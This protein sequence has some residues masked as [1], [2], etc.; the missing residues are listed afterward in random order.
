MGRGGMGIVYKARQ[1]SLNRPVAL[2]MIRSAALASD[3]ELRRFQNEAEAVAAARP[4]AHR[5]DPGSGRPRRPALFQHEADRRFQP[6][7]EARRLHRRP[8]CRRDGC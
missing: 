8:E 5:P 2:K 4:S 7:Q 6:G 1:I 3:D